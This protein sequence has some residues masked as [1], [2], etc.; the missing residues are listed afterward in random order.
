M[1]KQNDASN[2]KAQE[3]FQKKVLASELHV[4]VLDKELFDLDLNRFDIE[5]DFMK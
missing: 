5:E 4:S 3:A 1:S 2:D